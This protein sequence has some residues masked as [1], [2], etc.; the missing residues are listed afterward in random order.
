MVQ[1]MDK[2]S[3][4]IL[5]NIIE[6]S[7]L[8]QALNPYQDKV[9]LGAVIPNADEPGIV[10][11]LQGSDV[12]LVSENFGGIETAILTVSEIGR[13]TDMGIVVFTHLA[14]NNNPDS[15]YRRRSSSFISNGANSYVSIGSASLEHL[16]EAMYSAKTGYMHLPNMA[17]LLER[18]KN[19]IIDALLKRELVDE[20]LTIRERDVL[21]L[22]LQGH[23]NSEI[24]SRLGVGSGT[25]E[26]FMG[27]IYD[28][29]GILGPNKDRKLHGK[30][31]R[32]A[33]GM[34]VAERQGYVPDLSSMRETETSQEAQLVNTE[35]VYA[36]FEY[37]PDDRTVIV[38]GRESHLTRAE[39]Q[40]LRYF[41]NNPG[42]HHRTEIS[43][44]AWG[45]S[46]QSRTSFYKTLNSLKMV[47]NSDS[48]YAPQFIYSVHGE[49]FRFS[50]NPEL[51]YPP[52]FSYNPNTGV[53]IIGNFQKII[54]SQLKD[55]VDILYKNVPQDVIAREIVDKI[56]GPGTN[57]RILAT[58]MWLL[59]RA[60]SVNDLQPSVIY[61]TTSETGKAYGLII[62]QPT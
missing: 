29:L 54:R 27:K 1:S 20:R 18:Q 53:A 35:K 44:G 25:A 48:P 13:K 8:S 5:A 3:A 33:T 32:I 56:W 21:E 11:K 41:V 12:V 59:R 57:L 40:L 52:T 51:I 10:D 14:P 43:R 17:E 60:L 2:I 16:I 19:M 24:A 4:A 22:F 42:L 50:T 58:P 36:G 31:F 61:S 45:D 6:S 49:L 26:H 55:I 34:S 37:R 38:D 39:N 15:D 23:G 62:R 28:K 30:V 9:E 7:G 46:R 47:L